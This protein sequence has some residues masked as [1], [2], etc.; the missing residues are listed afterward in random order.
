MDNY[1]PFEKIE[2]RFD[3]LEKKL[4]DAGHLPEIIDSRE[5]MRRLGISEPTFIKLKRRNKIVG[6]KV[7]GLYRF[8]W[9]EV[10]KAL[11]KT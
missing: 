7:G 10:V 8:D 9:Y 1:N 2:E 5:L 4:E 3:N 6:F 11:K